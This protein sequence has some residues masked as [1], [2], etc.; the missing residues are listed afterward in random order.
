ML[1]I[2]INSIVCYYI[3]MSIITKLW[4]GVKDTY[5]QVAQET[6]TE[7]ERVKSCLDRANQLNNIGFAI[8]CYSIMTLFCDVHAQLSQKNH[9]ELTKITF[10]QIASI[11]LFWIGH[12]TAVL[13][14]GY[15][16]AAT[17]ISKRVHT[18]IFS[19]LTIMP[20]WWLDFEHA[21]T[22]TMIFK[23]FKFVTEIPVFLLIKFNFLS[24]E[25][26]KK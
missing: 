4:S 16:S 22:N 3:F 6:V 10:A 13:A 23:A 24:C 9:I 12:D 21:A 8:K 14:E 18:Y 26:L 20:A 5:N 19:K 25:P 17:S 2:L 1:I 15:N 11:T 7:A